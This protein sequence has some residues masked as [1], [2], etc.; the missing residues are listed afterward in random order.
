VNIQ[1]IGSRLVFANAYLLV[2]GERI[3]RASAVFARNAGALAAG[4]RDSHDHDVTGAPVTP[5]GL[6]PESAP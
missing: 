6:H 2:G 4:Q 1:K 3:A 5:S